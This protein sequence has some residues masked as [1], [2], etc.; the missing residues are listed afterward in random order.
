MAC[1]GVIMK[2]YMCNEKH[3]KSCTKCSF[4]N[5]FIIAIIYEQDMNKL[6]NIWYFAH[7]FTFYY[8]FF[9]NLSL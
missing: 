6:L 2:K 3:Y 4:K 8:R 9:S 1:R 5:N 7:F